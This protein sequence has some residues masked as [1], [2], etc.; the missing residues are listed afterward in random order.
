[1]KKKALLSWSVLLL[2]LGGVISYADT[3]QIDIKTGDV[4]LLVLMLMSS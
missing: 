3:Y 4:K 2:S 1:M